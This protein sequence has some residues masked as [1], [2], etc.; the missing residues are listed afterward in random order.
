MCAT[1]PRI[2]VS[3]LNGPMERKTIAGEE[4]EVGAAPFKNSRLMTLLEV[5]AG[6]WYRHRLDLSLKELTIV[7]GG[8]GEE[9]LLLLVLLEV[10]EAEEEDQGGSVEFADKR[11]THEIIVPI[12]KEIK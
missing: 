5:E 1:N 9:V 7:E 12:M 8:E 10:N 2:R 6:D 11:D 4:A 3:S